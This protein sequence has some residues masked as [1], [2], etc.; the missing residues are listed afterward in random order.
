MM[1][2][3]G[4]L[5]GMGEAVVVAGWTVTFYHLSGMTDETL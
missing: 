4:V 5:N 2:A 3:D 1:T